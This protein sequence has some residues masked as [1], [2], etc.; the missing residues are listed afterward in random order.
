QQKRKRK[1]LDGNPDP[2]PFD[3]KSLQRRKFSGRR[4]MHVINDCRWNVQAVPTG[5]PASQT[6]IG[7]VTVGKELLVKN[8]DDIEHLPPIEGGGGIRKQH[9]FATLKLA[10][11]RFAGAATMIQ[12]VRV[13]KVPDFVDAFAVT[14]EQYLACAHADSGVRLHPI[15][16]LFEPARTRF[17][18]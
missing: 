18:I 12:A 2:I 8:A 15:D 6:E 3:E 4:R 7:V 16:Q 14:V 9:L 13:N 1:C 5:K 17:R 10:A 11:I